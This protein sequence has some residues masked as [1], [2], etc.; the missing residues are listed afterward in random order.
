MEALAKRKYQI[1][2]N[3]RSIII[4]K[5]NYFKKTMYVFKNIWIKS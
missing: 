5:N 3:L 2:I 1:R 4:R